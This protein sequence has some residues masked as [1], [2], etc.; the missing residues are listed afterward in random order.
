MLTKSSFAAVFF[1]LDGTLIDS[2]EDLAGSC[3]S[4]LE[5]NGF[6][7]HPVDAYRFFV[8]DGV[9]NLVRRAAAREISES[10]LTRLLAGM[11]KE[12][13]ARWARVTKPYSGIVHMLTRLEKAR[14]PLAVLSNKPH[15][16]TVLTVRHFFPDTPFAAIQGSPKGGKAKPDPSLAL[17]LAA[18]LNLA[19][20]RILFLGDTRTDMM[21]GTAAGMCPVG[22]LWGFRPKEELLEHGAE[23]LLESPDQLFDYL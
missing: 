17:A 21:T 1:D 6:A 5:A 12:Y 22:V 15:D 19:P 20:E 9:E 23:I 16:M 18:Q 7:P 8:G 14:I 10:T 2:L 11:R 4:V 3:N 13:T